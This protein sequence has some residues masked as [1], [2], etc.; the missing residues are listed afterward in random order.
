MNSLLT[1]VLGN[2][3]GLPT[4]LPATPTQCSSFVFKTFESTPRSMLKQEFV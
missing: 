1:C 3:Q 2:K 4:Y